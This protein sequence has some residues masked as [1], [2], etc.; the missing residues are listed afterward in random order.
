MA[1]LDSLKK[2][3]KLN[4]VCTNCGDFMEVSIPKG[5]TIEDYLLSEKAKCTNCGC[6]TIR[7]AE[8]KTFH[9]SKGL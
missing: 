5:M 1:L 3:Y 4:V 6:N 8:G 7:K 2:I 9:K